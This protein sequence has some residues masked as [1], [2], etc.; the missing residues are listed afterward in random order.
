MPSRSVG[1]RTVDYPVLVPWSD[2]TF[3]VQ[4]NVSHSDFAV[5]LP[6]NAS[7][8]P[9]LL[10]PIEL[11]QTKLCRYEIDRGSWHSLAGAAQSNRLGVLDTDQNAHRPLPRMYRLRQYLTTNT[12]F[13]AGAPGASRHRS[14]VKALNVNVGLHRGK[15]SN[16]H[17]NNATSCE[18]GE[19]LS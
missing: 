17:R 12:K 9:C 8:E 14:A 10:T 16:D 11:W 15:E 2:S 19:H 4:H 3:Y 6:P 18:N 7:T 1:P 5:Q 13:N